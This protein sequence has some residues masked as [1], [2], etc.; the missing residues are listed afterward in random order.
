MPLY[1]KCIS[2]KIVCHGH[3]YTC[4]H[5]YLRKKRCGRDILRKNKIPIV[6]KTKIRPPICPFIF[7]T[8]D[9]IS[10]SLSGLS[11]SVSCGLLS[12][13]VSVDNVW[14]V[15]R[16]E[17]ESVSRGYLFR[18]NWYFWITSIIL[19]SSSSRCWVTVQPRYR[20]KLAIYLYSTAVLALCDM[21]WTEKG[22]YFFHFLSVSLLI[23]HFFL[24]F[25]ILK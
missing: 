11:A 16:C 15:N 25:L 24:F 22:L 14:T 13:V 2:T 4:F 10:L 5:F 6:A 23:R 17:Q 8:S 7:P 21:N 19:D 18:S 9:Y 1:W 3:H 12:Y 20:I